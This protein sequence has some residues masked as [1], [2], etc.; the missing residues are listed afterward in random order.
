MQWIEDIATGVPMLDKRN[1]EMINMLDGLRAAIRKQVCRHTIENVI[2][3]LAE[4]GEVQLC[5]EEQYMRNYDY[6]GHAAHEDKH[7]QF[8]GELHFLEE[9]LRNIRSL[10][11]KGSYELSVE[12]VK[13]ISDWI[14]GHVLIYDR[15]LGEFVR[16]CATGNDH[17]VPSGCGPEDGVDEKVVP[18]CSFCK[19]I[20]GNKGIWRGR[21]HFPGLPLESRYSH[22]LCPECLQKY[23]ADLFQEK[24]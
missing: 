6:P 23:Y 20:R 13:V 7:R 18:I 10:G 17:L 15:E 3:F 21:G 22:S 4:Y 14:Y 2:A 12:T 11:L 9:E 19:R 8:V 1:R 16:G 5:E 24:R